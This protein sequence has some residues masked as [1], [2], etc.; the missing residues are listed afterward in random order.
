MISQGGLKDRMSYLVAVLFILAI[1]CNSETDDDTM[2]GGGAA[3]SNGQVLTPAC[4][5]RETGNGWWS[6]SDWWFSSYGW[7]R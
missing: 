1:G 6:S 3:A 4:G 5:C 2:M 7:C